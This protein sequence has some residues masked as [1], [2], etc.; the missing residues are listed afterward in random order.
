MADRDVRGAELRLEGG[1]GGVDGGIPERF[2]SSPN[3]ENDGTHGHDAVQCGVI[4]MSKRNLKRV[5]RRWCGVPGLWH[6]VE[7]KSAGRRVVRDLKEKFA[8]RG[9]TKS[10]VGLRTYW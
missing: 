5:S 2:G 6:P 4:A 3:G 1:E 7:N 9:W 8:G 10:K